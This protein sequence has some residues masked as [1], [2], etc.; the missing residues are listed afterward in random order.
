MNLWEM[1]K[2]NIA[3]FV[4][5]SGTNFQNLESFCRKNLTKVKGTLVIGNKD[6][7]GAKEKAEQFNIPFITLKESDFSTYEL[8]ASALLDLL[9][10]HQIDLICLAGYLKKIPNEVIRHFNQRIINI[11]PSLLPSFGGK[12]MYGIRVH[13]AVL[14]RG[15]KISGASTHFVSD[16]YD[17][18]QLIIQKCIQI[19]DN[20]TP[21][22]LQT[23]VLDIEYQIYIE[24]ITTL[25]NKPWKIEDRIFKI[26]EG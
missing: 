6:Q 9:T 13:Q 5:G 22:T 8:Y 19:A 3:Y 7:I 26:G 4:S 18:G 20:E 15:C 1:E 11:H 10:T 17:E 21:E 14:V 23:K 16:Q 25:V 24:T 2:I 12:G